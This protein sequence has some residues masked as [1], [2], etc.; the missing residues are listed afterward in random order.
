MSGILSDELLPPYQRLIEGELEAGAGTAREV[1]DPIGVGAVGGSGTRLVAALLTHAGV[2]MASPI[3]K[4]GDALEW[5]PYRKLLSEELLARYSRETML[6]NAYRVFENLLASR[7]QQLGLSG[8]VGWKVPGTFHWIAELSRY[9]PRMQYLHLMRSGLDMAYSGNQVQA[10]NW[11]GVVG[12]ELTRDKNGRITPGSVLEYWLTANELALEKCAQYLPGR[13]YTLRF[14]QLC[15]Q[16][17]AELSSLLS[18]LGL[19]LSGSELDRLVA[20][21]KPPA[22]IGRYRHAPW[23]EDFSPAQLS[24]LEKLGY[25][26]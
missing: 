1:D 5:P 26:P 24:R 12:V 23:Q 3:N 4:A 17:H 21:V 13:A 20:M 22:S 15:S 10:S 11:A 19:A 14:E 8:R 2:A 18:F 9:F 7:R 6:S 16:P 25:T